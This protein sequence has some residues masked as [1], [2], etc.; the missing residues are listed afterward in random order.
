SGWRTT[1][2]AS[3]LQ[4][5]STDANGHS[6]RGQT[7]FA[8]GAHREQS[9]SQEPNA[10]ED[11]GLVVQGMGSINNAVSADDR[12]PGLSPKFRPPYRPSASMRPLTPPSVSRQ[13]GTAQPLAEAIG[14]PCDQ[15]SRVACFRLSG[16]RTLSKHA[17]KVHA[18]A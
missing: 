15:A 2:D 4:R 17:A 3:G 7:A 9:G 10:A 18:A 11:A 5:P 16:C 14:C 8:P 13:L 6:V 12:A 1:T